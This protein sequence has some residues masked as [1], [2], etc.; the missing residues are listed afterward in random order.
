[1]LVLSRK[2]NESIVIGDNIEICITKVDGDT[3][4]VGIKAPREI[5]VYRK[6]VLNAVAESNQQAA[7]TGSS[8]TSLGSLAGKLK[9]RKTGRKEP[10]S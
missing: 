9:A 8:K 4:R 6:E 1:M 7:L 3:V 5:P 10:S 2:T